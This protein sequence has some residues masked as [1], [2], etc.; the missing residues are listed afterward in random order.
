MDELTKS[1]AKGLF[2][3]GFTKEEVGNLLSISDLASLEEFSR[4]Q[5]GIDVDLNQSSSEFYSELQK[6]LSKLVFTEMNKTTRDSSVILNA[7]KLQAELQ[8]KKLAVNKK[9]DLV[10]I[11]K[12]YIQDREQEINTL[13]GQGKSIIELAK[14]FN[15]SPLSIKHSLDRIQLDLPAELFELNPSIIT[16]TIGLTKEDRLKVL[17]AAKANNYTRKSVRELV[18]TIK[19]ER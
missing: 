15:V 12:N 9:I 7:I 19:N 17:T 8:E 13:H 4:M 3:K 6:D 1:K 5:A 16:E 2:L 11:T 10:K 18:N 14:Q